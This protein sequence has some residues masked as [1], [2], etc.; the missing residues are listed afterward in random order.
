MQCVI[1]AGGLGTRMWPEARSV[2][3]TLLPVQDR[4]FAD[5]QL[6]WL[7]ASGIE[8]VVY[9]IGY[10]GHEVRDFVGNGARWG[11]KVGYV[12]EG[13]ELRG[14]AG[15]L[16]LALD[17]GALDEDFLVLYGDSWLQVNPAS[18]LR[19]A[20]GRSE[21]ALMTVFRNDGR[22][23]TSN[24]VF[25]GDLVARYEKGLDPRP[26][27]MR[28]IDYGLTALR[29]DLIGSRVPPASVQDLATLCTALAREGRL[30]GYE[31][32][33]RFYEIGS[34]EGRDELEHFL[35]GRSPY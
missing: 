8:T 29:R 3:K 17:E 24:V 5:W 33:E 34:V 30:V 14:T 26:E 25:D 35:K 11:L 2:P 23:D 20:R 15:A 31:V 7:A 10:L 27:E 21:P 19:Y 6:N 32:T 13:E 9:C 16:R 12:D 18:V 1:L 4:P 22:W 28:W